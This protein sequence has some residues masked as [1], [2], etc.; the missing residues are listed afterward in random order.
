MKTLL[1][2]GGLFYGM[3]MSLASLLPG[4]LAKECFYP[5]IRGAVMS[6]TTSIATLAA[7]LFYLGVSYSY[8]LFGSFRISFLLAL[9]LCVITIVLSKK[10]ERQM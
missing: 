6:K 4:V 7:A 10:I 3:S 9:L 8:D 1:A 2:A 5:D